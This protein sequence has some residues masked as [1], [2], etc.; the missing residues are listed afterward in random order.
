MKIAEIARSISK[1]VAPVRLGL[2]L[3]VL[4]L[5]WLPIAI[6]IYLLVGNNA[7]TP[8]GI[9][10][11]SLF[12][13]LI[14]FWGRN[15]EQQAK[16]YAYYG[17]VFSRYS[18]LECIAGVCLGLVSLSALMLLQ[19]SLGWLVWQGNVN[20]QSAVLPGLLTGLGVGFAEELLFRGWLLT[21]LER[22]YGKSR[23]LL[24]NS[25]F[26]ALTHFIKTEPI[27]V[28]LSRLPQFP[29][30][31]LLGIDLIWARRSR[32]NR[33]GLAIGLHGGLVWGYYIVNTSHWLK[34]AEV[35]PEWVTGIGGNPLAGLMG[36][37]FLSAIAIG[38]WMFRTSSV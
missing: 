32:Q 28:L 33:L 27:L 21:E 19:A 35:V 37:L 29:G 23:S 18:L 31:M 7:G 25:S 15:V 5:L 34:S 17:L 20:W 10:L 14:W 24:I 3:L 8:L 6:P 2:F 13:A 38:L 4:L 9:L 26:F 16:P 30:L 36:L 1:F 12:V 11:Y 22:D